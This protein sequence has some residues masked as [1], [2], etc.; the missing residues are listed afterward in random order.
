MRLGSDLHGWDRARRA[1]SGP[2]KS[3][4]HR[5]HFE[6]VVVRVVAGTVSNG[7]VLHRSASG[8]VEGLSTA[9][10]A[11]QS[12]LKGVCPIGICSGTGRPRTADEYPRHW[13]R[14]LGRDRGRIGMLPAVF[15]AE[16]G[17]VVNHL[18]RQISSNRHSTLCPQAASLSITPPHSLNHLASCVFF[19]PP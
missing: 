19:F 8:G 6:I 7:S 15:V 13:C 3:R 18:Q 14:L 2:P 1:E 10:E 17:V 5:P 11:G 4:T 16:E 9:I 12:A